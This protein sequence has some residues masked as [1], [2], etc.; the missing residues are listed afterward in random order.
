MEINS[1]HCRGKDRENS[2]CKMQNAELFSGEG[3]EFR[4]FKEVREF[5]DN[6][7]GDGNKKATTQIALR[8][9]LKEYLKASC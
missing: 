8:G 1:S 5:R 3:R 7:L 9:R 6:L 2:K 4:E